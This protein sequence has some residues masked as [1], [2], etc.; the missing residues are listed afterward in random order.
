[1]EWYKNVS[2]WILDK[3]KGFGKSILNGIK[4][5]LEYIVHQQNLHG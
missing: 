4:S 2:K 5:I 3:I 1:M